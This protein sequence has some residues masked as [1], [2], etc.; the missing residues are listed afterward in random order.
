MT[1]QEIAKI[2]R[3]I[4]QI[5][6]VKDENPFRIRAYE[7]AAQNIENLTQDL[8]DLA[9]NNKLTS[10]PGIGQDL[11]FK[12]KEVLET[13]TLKYYEELKKSTPPGLLKI[14]EIPSVGPKTAKL[15]YEKLK[16]DSI[17]KLEEFA[18]SGKLYG[19][20]GI[21]EKTIENI[22]KGIELIKKG[23]ERMPLYKALETAFTF[24]DYLKSFSIVKKISEAGSVRRRKDTIKDIDI[25]VFTSN[26]LKVSEEFV[27]FKKVKEILAKGATK[28]SVLTDGDIQ[29]DLRVVDPECFGSALM[30]FTGS[31]AFNIK[32]RQ[33]AL[34]SGY[35]VNEYG[36]F[37]GEK[38][39]CGAT[40][41]EIFDFFGMEYILPELREDQGEIELALNKSLPKVISFED[42][43]G[44]FHIH[45]KYSDGAH[46]IKEIAEFCRKLGYEYVAICDH[47][48]SLKVAGGVSVEDLLKKIEEV[49]RINSEYKDFKV[50]CGAEVDILNDGSLDYP[51]EI[52]EKLDLV[53]AAIHTGFKQS[54]SQ[55]TKRIIKACENRYVD[56]IAH[57]TGR[58]WGQREGYEIDLEE[59]IKVCLKTQTALEI[60]CFPQRLDLNDINAKKAV[61]SGV[62]LSLGA[63]AHI[64]DQVYFLELGVSVA[65]RAWATKDNVLNCWSVEKIEKWRKKRIE[66]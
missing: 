11:A 27:N 12:I 25:L 29:V 4:A 55:L 65:R 54:K 10:I 43:K 51:Q 35:K 60:N 39:V 52:L 33:L 9:K 19:L 23:K 5:L 22:L 53:I 7:K 16:I 32:F 61:E 50:L 2:F 46:T 49:K 8:K 6:S 57:P 48:Q 31:K 47:S 64:L 14:L 59:I 13:G 41:E 56:I 38:R 62:L 3:E 66:S 18:K 34:R 36:V 1:N 42:I 20:P 44:D 24:I 30:Y 40:E 45:S 21:G 63:D 58:L 17:E 15:L 26:P 37:K 28:S